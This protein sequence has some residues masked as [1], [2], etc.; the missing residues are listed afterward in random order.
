MSTIGFEASPG[1][2]VEPT[3][4]MP[5]SSHGASTRSSSARSASK[6]SGHSG[7]YG[8]TTTGSSAT[9]LRADPPERPT[10][11][12]GGGDERIGL[13]DGALEAPVDE[14]AGA[15]AVPEVGRRQSGGDTTG[16]EDVRR[17]VRAGVGHVPD[18]RIVR[19]GLGPEP[20]AFPLG[21]HVVVPVHL[22]D[23]RHRSGGVDDRDASPARVVDH[24]V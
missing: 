15:P 1:T 23:R 18:Q 13:P 8:T 9:G 17:V 14:M 24:P 3:W 11:E 20:R 10:R 21:G 12:P 4:W 6:R 16:S 22:V 2:A 19:V 5:P 7:S